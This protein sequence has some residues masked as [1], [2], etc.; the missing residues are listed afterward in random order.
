MRIGN[1]DISRLQGSSR[2]AQPFVIAEIG[3]NHD[4]SADRAIK[5]I[6]QAANTGADAVKFQYFNAHTLLSNEAKLAVY[7]QASG[8]TDPLE[9]LSRLELSLEA[10]SACCEHAISN[11]I[12]PIVTAFSLEDLDDILQLPWSAIKT[13]SPDLINKPLL[14]RLA[15]DTRPLIIST[16]AASLDEVVRTAN[17]LNPTLDS[18]CML[19]CVSSY[20]V[21][22]G[23]DALD[24]IH[25]IANAAPKL[26]AV[27]YSDHTP[28]TTTGKQA[29]IRGAAILEKHFTDD[30]NRQGPDHAA[31][32]NPSDFESYVTKAKSEPVGNPFNRTG[33]KQVL[34]CEQD[35]RKLSRQ[36]IA[37]TRDMQAGHVI[38]PRD[39]TVKRPGTGI[40]PASL[41]AIIGMT[42]NTSVKQ[43]SLA[44]PEHFAAKQEA[45]A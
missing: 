45:A 8:E 32:L 22:Q 42:L 1:R 11:N 19:Q 9:M 25:A 12:E 5:L 20:P 26:G 18:I 24:G 10:L 23:M 27:G 3:V 13:A 36:S 38:T 30:T 29:V 14:K 15:S 35:V 33:S 40:A 16:G 39:I 7:Q 37:F 43:S 2:N 44:L 34:Q 28:L 21:P 17:W 4:G 31:S 6:D 41:D